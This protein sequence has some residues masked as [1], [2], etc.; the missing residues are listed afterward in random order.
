MKKIVKFTILGIIILAAVAGGI[1]SKTA[2]IIV[3]LT[4]ITAKTAELSFTEQGLAVAEDVVQVYAMAQGRVVQ[5][6]AEEGQSVKKGDVLCM[7]DSEPLLLKVDQIQSVIQGYEAQIAN[8]DTEQERAKNDLQTSKN[9][10][11]AELAAL[12]AQK[13]SSSES[14]EAQNVSVEESLRLQGILIE[15][16][17]KDLSRAQ[18]E[19]IKVE[20]LYNAGSLPRNEYDNAQAAVAGYESAL[21]AAEQQLAVIA[22]GRG[23]SS[24]AYYEAAQNSLN[25]QIA[26]IDQSLGKDYTGAM[27]EYYQ[28]LTQGN[29]VN[30]AQ[31]E[32]EI[33][34][35]TVTAPVDGVI[36]KLSV[37]NTNMVSSAAP[38][39]EITVPG[40]NMIEVYVSTKDVD[41]IKAGDDVELTLKRREGDAV[42]SGE[43][44]RIDTTA[45]VKL[46]A[47]GV[48]ERKVKLQVKPQVEALEAD[49]SFGIGY[50]VDVKFFVYRA[51]N[52]LTVPKTALFKDGD[53]DMLWVVRDGKAEAI[54]VATGMELRTETV[55]ASGLH[56]G[57]AVVTDANNQNVKNGV[58]VRGE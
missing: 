20:A 52:Q 36:T 3:P 10:L 12:E 5:V 15:Q 55:I 16:S 48:E 9:S 17:K 11:R 28:A 31:I 22:G 53:R 14:V 6:N 35:C 49:A 23:Q 50:S 27:K 45:E 47:L 18:D 51:E 19:L 54:E 44:T 21:E 7:V 43:V 24:E 40:G 30:I 46:S 41:S 1:Y 8:L 58:K 2:P 25:A 42:F 32:N 13:R 39:A 38:V 4:Q 33:A 37:R 56:E 26:G 29:V 34:N 57:D